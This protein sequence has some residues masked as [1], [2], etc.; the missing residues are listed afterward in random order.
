MHTFCEDFDDPNFKNH[1]TSSVVKTGGALERDL[2]SFVSP[3]A[4]LHA[5]VAS[6]SV[7]GFSDVLKNFSGGAPTKIEMEL[8][9]IVDVVGAQGAALV[10]VQFNGGTNVATTLY[11]SQGNL[12]LNVETQTPIEA[13]F[14]YD[15]FFSQGFALKKGTWTHVKLQFTFGPSGATATVAIDKALPQTAPAPRPVVGVG[16]FTLA[17]GVEHFSNAPFEAWDL[18]VDD[19]TLD[20]R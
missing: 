4:A 17:L 13:G 8:D 5:A 15:N 18:H 3:P 16:A 14:F 1:W 12:Y 11:A 6:G 19:F 7:A 20:V 10:Q 2:A 9:L